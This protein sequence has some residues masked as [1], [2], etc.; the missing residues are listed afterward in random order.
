MATPEAVLWDLDGVIVDS[1]RFH[2]EAFQQL[3]AEQGRDLSEEEFGRLF[4]RQNDDI[5]RALLGDL[6]PERVQE[7][8]ARKERLF[9]ERIA[10]RIEALPGAVELVRRL[11]RAGVKQAIVSS[12]PRENIE[13]IVHSLGIDSA[14]DTLVGE[15]DA[16]RGKPDPQPFL[17]AAERLGVT[18]EQCL[19][20]EDAP[21]GIE[22]AKR[23][24]MRAI[25]IATTR[26]GEQLST[27]D[28]VVDAL[29]DER[30]ERLLFGGQA[31]GGS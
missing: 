21:E 31:G 22:A 2:F 27:A 20:F 25:G 26:Q 5:L 29:T 28:E 16:W 23:A 30:V 14:L 15:E 4:G 19:V 12:T 10:G 13:L 18:P 6:P 17:I 9:R 7:L 8:A 24:G 3:M 1:G 11:A